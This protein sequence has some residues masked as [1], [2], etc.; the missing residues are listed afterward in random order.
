MPRTSGLVT[1]TLAAVDCHPDSRRIKLLSYFLLRPADARFTFASR[2]RQYDLQAGADCHAGTPGI[3]SS[4]SSLSIGCFVD[5]NGR[6]NLRFASRAACPAVYVGV[7]GTGGDIA[8]LAKA[9]DQAV[10]RSVAGPRQLAGRLPVGGLRCQRAAC[11][12][13]RGVQGPCAHGPEAV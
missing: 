1:G 3:E 4:R 12:D 5:A 11:A 7:L 9:Y 8:T 13:E 2:M 6:A 10:G